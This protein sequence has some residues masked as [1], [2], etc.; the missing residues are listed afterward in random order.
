[1]AKTGGNGGPALF[2]GCIAP[3]RFPDIESATRFVFEKLDVN[4][5]DLEGFACCATKASFDNIDEVAALAISSRNI[6]LAEEANVDLVTI[7]NG[8][9]SI[10]AEAKHE[11]DHHPEKLAEVQEVLSKIER[12]YKGSSKVL[13]LV[14]YLHDTVGTSKIA[15]S[16]S[17]HL[18]G[19]RLAVFYG[20]HYL[21]PSEVLQTDDPDNPM[22]VNDIISALGGRSV[23]YPGQLDCCGAGGGVRVRDL[24][25]SLEIADQR[26]KAISK[27]EV[28]AIVTPCP[29]C[30]LQLDIGQG[31]LNDK[32]ANYSIPVLHL[33]QLIA[34]TQGADPQKVA[35]FGKTPRDEVIAKI[36]GDG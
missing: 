34:L 31:L 28:E 1:M 26:L 8:C 7:C 19:M 11:L 25:T 23:P 14:Q 30:F 35:R 6:A 16:V 15:S 32:G 13:H 10:L 29:F 20:C 27:A 24:E 5:Q 33:S 4:V 2:L 9:F 21:R 12:S 18:R 22:K 36:R 17:H 3:L